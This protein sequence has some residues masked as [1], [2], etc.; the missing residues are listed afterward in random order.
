MEAGR[1]DLGAHLALLV[2]FSFMHLHLRQHLSIV[3]QLCLQE[4]C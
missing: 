4:V 3:Q 1:I 2:H